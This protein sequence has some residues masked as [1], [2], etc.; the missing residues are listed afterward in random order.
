MRDSVYISEI[1]R[2]KCRL[3]RRS[4]DDSHIIQTN[5]KYN[6][7]LNGNIIEVVTAV[8]DI[9]GMRRKQLSS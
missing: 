3:C 6:N 9:S 4:I 2:Q 7:K 8:L 1:S 5:Y